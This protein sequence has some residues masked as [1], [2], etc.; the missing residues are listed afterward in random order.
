MA[1]R[2]YVNNAPVT[3][4]SGGV[5]AIATAIPVVTATG[6]PVTFPWT[7]VID[8]GTASAEIVLV[9][10]AVGTTLTVTRGFD[11]SGG[12]SHALGAVFAHEAV[13]ADYDEANAHVNTAA[14]VVGVHGLAGALVGTTDI[15]TLSNKTLTS[16]TVNGGIYTA[17]FINSQTATLGVLKN[18]TNQGDATHPVVM[19]QATTVS[20]ILLKLQNSAAVDKFTVDGAGSVTSAG[21]IGASSSLSGASA[22][23]V[24]AI[25]AASAALTGAL[26]SATVTSTKVI[27]VLTPAAYAD[28]AALTAAI[29]VPALGARAV[30]GGIEYIYNGTAWYP[31]MVAGSGSYSILTGTAAITGT[32]NFGVTFPSAPMVTATLVNS[33]N[34]GINVTA[35]TTTNFSWRAFRTPGDNATSPQPGTFSWMTA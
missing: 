27:A 20:G 24:G 2:H 8:A 7:G 32:T 35:I 1:R 30:A 19:G 16:P 21:A 3:T 18:M 5:T 23:I 22:Q 34:H 31:A 28:V 13:Q 4:L 29:T 25:T 12:Q 26:T 6:F 14:G 10:S 11:G 9:T 15:Q 17:P 33:G